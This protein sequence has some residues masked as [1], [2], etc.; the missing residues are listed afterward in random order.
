MASALDR[1][2]ALL[3]MSD[4]DTVGYLYGGVEITVVID[5]ILGPT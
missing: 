5:N 3:A 4:R 2:E 1:T